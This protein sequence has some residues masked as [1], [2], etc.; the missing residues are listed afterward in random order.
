MF[1]FMLVM[2]EMNLA[3]APT[4]RCRQGWREGTWGG[5]TLAAILLCCSLWEDVLG[6]SEHS[7]GG[8]PETCPPSAADTK[9][10]DK[11]WSALSLTYCLCIIP[12]GDFSW[13]T[14]IAILFSQ[15]PQDDMEVA[16]STAPNSLFR[17]HSTWL[18]NFIKAGL[19]GQP[20]DST[21]LL[22]YPRESSAHSCSLPGYFPFQ[23]SPWGWSTDP[24]PF[25]FQLKPD[26]SSVS[27][28]FSYQPNT[29][30][31]VF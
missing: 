27:R 6:K 11:A 17:G 29:G 4:P 7:H 24:Q 3:G 8:Y 20:C 5:W 15:P 25:F 23:P 18:S 28:S 30:Y 10:L 2:G 22:V 21:D 16:F 1:V 31:T 13:D 9:L 26:T 14:L 12:S 19:W